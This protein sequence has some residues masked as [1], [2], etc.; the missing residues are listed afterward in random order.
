MIKINFCSLLSIIKI[1]LKVS[2]HFKFNYIII[3][4][5]KCIYKGKKNVSKLYYFILER[6]NT[7]TS[8]NVFER[9]KNTSCERTVSYLFNYLIYK[10]NW[11]KTKINSQF[12]FKRNFSKYIYCKEKERGG[13]VFNS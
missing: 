2:S 12:N 11:N 5:F 6:K 9:S 8:S 10:Y 13:V 4:A 3:Y 1:I 7:R